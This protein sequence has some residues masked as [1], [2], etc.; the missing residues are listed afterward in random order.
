MRILHL[1]SGREMRGGQWQ[2][3]SLLG[4]LGGGN[5][6]LT[7]A[8]GPLMRAASQQ[9]IDVRP[10]S[11]LAIAS[12]GQQSD[13]IHAHDAR[14]HTWAA[15]VPGTP[16]VVSRRVA[17]AVGRSFLSRWKYRRAQRYL[18]VSEHVKRTLINADV[19]ESRITVVYDGVAIPERASEGD[20]IIA[21]RT[22]DPMK[23][24]DLLDRAAALGNF[25]V[26]YSSNLRADLTS[27]GLFVYITRSEGLGSAALMAM[28]AGVPVV[29]SN[30]GGLPEVV[31][32]CKSGILTENT[33]QAI[34]DAVALAFRR[35]DELGHRA[36]R[37]MEE[38][39]SVDQMVQRTRQAYLQV[40][41]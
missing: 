8:N 31:E 26:H 10:L 4:A 1:D 18:A 34:A 12:L 37:A 15:S 28:A 29:A 40:L 33:P 13:L 11:F 23:G 6:L 14:S 7:P 32:H 39:F 20:R 24:T 36:R 22:D 38:R 2:V 25:T 35:R 21:I 9:G 5:V 41:G 17:F 19:P 16:L 3:L 27:A 30:V